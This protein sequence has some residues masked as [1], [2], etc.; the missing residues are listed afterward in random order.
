M[1]SS[2]CMSCLLL[3]GCGP[4]DTPVNQPAS[5]LDQRALYTAV[6]NNTPDQPED[7]S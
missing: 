3:A 7:A 5:H 2:A 1:K 4:S 6:L